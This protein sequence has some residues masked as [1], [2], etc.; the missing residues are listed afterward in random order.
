M[1]SR[2]L[3]CWYSDK[4][5][6]KKCL[7]LSTINYHWQTLVQWNDQYRW[8]FFVVVCMISV[9]SRSS[10]RSSVSVNVSV[11]VK[12]SLLVWD[13]RRKP[14]V[15]LNETKC[16]YCLETYSFPEIHYWYI[17]WCNKF[18]HYILHNIIHMVFSRNSCRKSAKIHIRKKCA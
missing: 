16:Q 14:S 9:K 7:D 13:L 11:N 8:V 5:E 3:L 18:Y 4:L 1:E 10:R 17:V 12:V 6:L 15:C 2:T